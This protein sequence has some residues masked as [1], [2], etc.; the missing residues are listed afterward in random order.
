MPLQREARVNSGESNVQ[1]HK[2]PTSELSEHMG[3]RS[4]WVKVYVSVPQLTP[5]QEVLTTLVIQSK[6]FLFVYL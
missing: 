1:S 3:E 6:I 5:G 2:I 4:Y